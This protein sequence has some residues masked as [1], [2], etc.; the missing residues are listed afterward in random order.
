LYR[1]DT[2]GYNGVTEDE[3]QTDKTTFNKFVNV[4][5]SKSILNPDKYAYY[6]DTILIGSTTPCTTTNVDE[7]Y[8]LN[9]FDGKSDHRFTEF[10]V[11]TQP[12][13]KRRS[14]RTRKN[15][16]TRKKTA[17]KYKK[18]ARSAR[19]NRRRISRKP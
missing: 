8:N 9:V 4:E 18:K 10:V 5:Y 6:G 1:D 3:V 2:T 16:R 11:T 12:G 13:G 7:W 15:R 17:R 14:R 19:R